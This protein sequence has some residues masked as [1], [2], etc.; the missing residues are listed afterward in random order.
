VATTEEIF[1]MCVKTVDKIKKL[2]KDHRKTADDH[3]TI[4]DKEGAQD[5]ER[6]NL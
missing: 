2:I 4:I 1:A 5:G 3:D 6:E